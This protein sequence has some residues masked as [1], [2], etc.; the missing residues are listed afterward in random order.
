M[1]P[2]EYHFEGVHSAASSE[3]GEF[4]VLNVTGADGMCGLAVPA[5]T[6]PRVCLALLEA[7]AE[8][9]RRTGDKTIQSSEIRSMEV[10]SHPQAD[11]VILAITVHSGA[12]PV[13]FSLPE[14]TLV[15]FALG[16]LEKRGLLTTERSSK[17]Q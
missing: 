9:R 6:I 17:L 16:V 11:K 5:K 14:S 15:N 10:L 3:D 13:G 1:A 8:A 7:D 4:V 12:A 2:T